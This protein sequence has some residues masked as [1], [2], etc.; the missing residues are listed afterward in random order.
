MSNIIIISGGSSKIQ[1]SVYALVGS[2][3]LCSWYKILIRAISKV[4]C[5]I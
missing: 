3:Y 4:S 5:L 1:V 2:Y